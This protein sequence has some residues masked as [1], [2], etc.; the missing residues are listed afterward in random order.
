MPNHEFACLNRAWSIICQIVTTLELGL[1]QFVS[2]QDK[3]L[4]LLYLAR[5]A[6]SMVRRWL[7]LSACLEGSWP[8]IRLSTQC[9]QSAT[10]A[11]PN[12]DR[13]ASAPKFPLF[14]PE[15]FYGPVLLPLGE[16]PVP[17]TSRT[18][19]NQ[20]DT[21]PQVQFNLSNLKRR[22]Q[23][24]ADVVEDPIKHK[25]RMARWLARMAELRKT[26]L[27]KVHPFRVGFPPGASHALKRR[28][29]ERQSMLNYLDRLAREAVDRG[30]PP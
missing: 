1:A 16:V 6:E 11:K 14:E 9:P 3:P 13:N 5:V 10:S 17:R 29:P 15:R 22:F 23:A 25:K 28:D 4:K 7:V 26:H 24:L 18:D 8:T 30:P 2:G 20:T 12:K 21:Q 19:P 27:V